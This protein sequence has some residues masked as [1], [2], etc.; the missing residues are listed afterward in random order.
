MQLQ[1]RRRR[2][3]WPLVGAGL[4]LPLLLILLFVHQG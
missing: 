3:T 1:A 4:A 2:S